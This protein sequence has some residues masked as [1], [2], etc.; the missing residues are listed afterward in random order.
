[1][2]AKEQAP[3]PAPPVRAAAARP[4]EPSMAPLACG[5]SAEEAPSNCNASHNQQV[6]PA[7]CSDLARENPHRVTAPAGVRANLFLLATRTPSAKHES[8]PRPFGSATNSCRSSSACALARLVTLL[9]LRLRLRLLAAAKQQQGSHEV[10]NG[11]AVPADG[12]ADQREARPRWGE[13]SERQRRRG[14][15]P[16]A[17]AGGIR[18]TLT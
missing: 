5:Q 16:F 17:A 12:Y 9:R 10:G 7:G 8:R 1:M 4:W 11:A 13:P 3:L 15:V 18:P 2:T 14:L 6:S